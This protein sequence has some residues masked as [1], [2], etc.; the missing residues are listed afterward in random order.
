MSKLNN[1][2]SIKDIIN[3]IKKVMANNET[4]PVQDT[5]IVY[6]ENP[7]NALELNKNK[8]NPY[9]ILSD[10]DNT[11]RSI[12]EQTTHQYNITSNITTSTCDS[13]ELKSMNL[14]EN[15]S[16]IQENEST[17][18]HVTNFSLISEENITAT[19]EEVKKLIN[20]IH[21]P[22]KTVNHSNITIEELVINIIKPEL[23][24]WLNKNL[25]KLV[26]SIIE[27]EISQLVNNSKSQ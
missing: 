1:F 10:I 17:T 27:K 25:Y 13:S 5:E 3:G 16:L 26:K 12:I 9:S 18:Q 15:S 8:Y 6:L 20:Q 7:E 4:Q 24:L 19:T 22:Q 23:S 21:K 2:Q 14:T 11:L